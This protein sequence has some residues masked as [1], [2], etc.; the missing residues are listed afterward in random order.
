MWHDVRCCEMMWDEI[1]HTEGMQMCS[2]FSFVF[3]S[4]VI[5]GLAEAT[6]RRTEH[7]TEL[8]LEWATQGGVENMSSI[9]LCER[10][11]RG[12]CM[13][14]PEIW[15]LK[16]SKG[17]NSADQRKLMWLLYVA[18]LNIMYPK[19]WTW[20]YMVQPTSDDSEGRTSFYGCCSLRIPKPC[21]AAL[22]WY[23]YESNPLS[24][25]QLSGLGI[26]IVTYSDTKYFWRWETWNGW[27]MLK[28]KTLKLWLFLDAIPG[29]SMD[30]LSSSWIIP[31]KFDTVW[32]SHTA[33]SIYLPWLRMQHP[34]H[35]PIWQQG[36]AWNILSGGALA[37]LEKRLSYFD[38]LCI[39]G[40]SW[41][42]KD[43][44]IAPSIRH[45]PLFF[46]WLRRQLQNWHQ[47]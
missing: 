16:S 21:P 41:L 23:P 32:L 15:H 22:W 36:C 42:Q 40:S 10:R 37:T 27:K 1:L 29:I 46:S 43:W 25:R 7:A 20:R 4:G 2:Q 19:W 13:D 44:S 17:G 31:I 6:L 3:V 8:S 38:L 35:S 18:L 33:A 9:F 5:G 24:C 14:I 28:V 26:V 12:C 39:R 30:I 47:Q 45:H 34:H 11:L